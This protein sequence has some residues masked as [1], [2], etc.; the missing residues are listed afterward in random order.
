[1]D[2]MHKDV[3]GGDHDGSCDY[4]I[5]SALV[6]TI[7]MLGGVQALCRRFLGWIVH[8]LLA[9]VFA[10]VRLQVRDVCGIRAVSADSCSIRTTH[11]AAPDS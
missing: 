11:Q 6:P 9:L 5:R 4:N 2:G 3:A 8:F 10:Q 1:M 7:L